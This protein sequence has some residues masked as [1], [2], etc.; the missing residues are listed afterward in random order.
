MKLLEGQPHVLRNFRV[1]GYPLKGVLKCH[2]CPLDLF[3]P[4]F[5]PV[6]VM[7]MPAGAFL[8]LGVLMAIFN[9]VKVH[10]KTVLISAEKPVEA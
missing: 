9:A 1:R 6:L 10:S 3:G 8:T 2:V 5:N 7:I 4:G